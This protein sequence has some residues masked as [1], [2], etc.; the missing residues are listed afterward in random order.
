MSKDTEKKPMNADNTSKVT[1][2]AENKTLIS[3]A[4]EEEEDEEI[5]CPF[6]FDNCNE[7]DFE[8]MCDGCREDRAESI[9]EARAD[10]YD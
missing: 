7:D 10:T 8:S 9:A 2:I 5:Q 1:K 3:P 6:G 4:K